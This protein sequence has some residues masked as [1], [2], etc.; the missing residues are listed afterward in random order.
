MTMLQIKVIIN[1]LKKTA[2]QVFYQGF[3]SHNELHTDLD[4]IQ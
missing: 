1:I 4:K 3:L 2:G